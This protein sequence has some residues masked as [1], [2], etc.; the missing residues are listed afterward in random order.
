MATLTNLRR[1]TLLNQ[2]DSSLVNRSDAC[3]N[4]FLNKA[5]R[6]ITIVTVIKLCCNLSL[7]DNGRERKVK[8]TRTQA[9]NT[10]HK[11]HPQKQT[12]HKGVPDQS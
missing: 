8:D 3:V 9:T 10:K 7:L 2:N 12:N 5:A 11:K 4:F 6:I 1:W